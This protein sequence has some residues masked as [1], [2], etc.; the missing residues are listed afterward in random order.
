MEKSPHTEAYQRDLAISF[1]N[2]GMALSEIGRLD[3]AAQ[4]FESAL[5]RERP[6]LKAGTDKATSLSNMG[7]IYNNK[8]MLWTRRGNSTE[9]SMDYVKAIDLQKR[10]LR[11]AAWR[12]AHAA[13]LS[14]HYGNYAHTLRD[15]GQLAEAMEIVVARRALWEGDAEKLF[16]VARELAEIYRRVP[17]IGAEKDAD[18]REIIMKAGG[19]TLRAAAAAG[20]PADR[21]H[22]PA[23]AAFDNATLLTQQP[24]S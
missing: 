7:G 20:L 3:E 2:L 8:G 21:L 15:E 10:A 5:K 6:L 18:L 24:T 9:A 17:T 13:L 16:G 4:Q 11:V 23:V 19:E 12:C 22:D 1:N 14:N